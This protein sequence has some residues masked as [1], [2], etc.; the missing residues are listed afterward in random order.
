MT[1]HRTWTRCALAILLLCLRARAALAGPLDAPNPQDRPRITLP[2]PSLE[3]VG[4]AG[5][6]VLNSLVLR[7]ELVCAQDDCRLR[8][9]QHYGLHN[10]DKT[11]ENTVR[12]GLAS[13]TG[14]APE[15]TLRDDRGQSLA[16]MAQGASSDPIWELKLAS[17]ERKVIALAHEHGSRSTRFLS[18]SWDTAPLAPWGSI[19]SAR[20]E[21]RL[22]LRMT[23]DALLEVSP[24]QFR[25]EGNLLYWEYEGLESLASH[26]LLMMAPPTYERMLGLL[27]AGAHRDLADLYA[28]LDEAARREGVPF[29]DQYPAVLGEL[30]A[31]LRDA[32]NDLEMRLALVALY[33][34]RSEALPHMRLNYVLL[35]AQELAVILEQQPGRADI[36]RS[37]ANAYYQAS[38]IA[39]QEGDPSGALVYLKKATEV[40]GADSPEIAK[41]QQ[42]LTMRWALE[43]AQ[44]GQVTE[45]LVQLEGIMAPG[46]EDHIMHYAPDLSY[47]RMD[48]YLSTGQRRAEYHLRPYPPK[49]RAMQ[50]D[51]SALA[52]R[53]GAL[54]GWEAHLAPVEGEPDSIRLVM[55]TN[56]GSLEGLA[57]RCEE[58]TQA[59]SEYDDLTT[60]LISSPWRT[61][62][63]SFG[64]AQNPWYE[65]FEYQERVD[66][67]DLAEALAQK[68]EYSGWRMVELRAAAPDDPQKQLERDLALVALRDQ[69]QTWQ[70]MTSG[71]HWVFHVNH[72][73]LPEREDMRWLV[74]WGQAR[75]MTARIPVYHWR[76][77]GISGL[78][79]LAFLALLVALASARH[80]RR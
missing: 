78:V 13:P 17:D 74:P 61:E 56:F 77:I 6:V 20:V 8:V 3:P 60:L 4:S 58:I 62:L 27:L 9:E 33:R 14:R 37:L 68:N 66:L 23:D 47:A 32:P 45:A 35:T 42:E 71:T 57:D 36:A 5:F 34:A 48:I 40:E 22:P 15:V 19:E 11:R 24:T 16:P 53:V 30:L 12:I 72:G 64:V 38:Q 31:A 46:L 1:R 41:A 28:D 50:A 29:P 7:A 44:R 69:N 65:V 2:E 55:E 43:L 25:R 67:S 18:W 52:E 79:L 73:D 80:R 26:G 54:G 59:L 39:S 63:L 21:V 76:T 70:H 49:A 51:M 75:E 10:R